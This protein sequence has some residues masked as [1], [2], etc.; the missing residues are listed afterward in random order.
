M[1]KKETWMFVD[2]ALKRLLDHK[3][4]TV[5]TVAEYEPDVLYAEPL[6]DLDWNV[7][8]QKNSPLYLLTLMS[9]DPQKPNY[10]YLTFE[11]NEDGV[12]DA[13]QKSGKEMR[14]IILDQMF[15]YINLST[16]LW[17]KL[18]QD[19]HAKRHDLLKLLVVASTSEFDRLLSSR[20]K[21]EYAYYFK[22]LVTAG[23]R[24][25]GAYIPVF[26]S[27]SWRKEF[28]DWKKEITRY[29]EHIHSGMETIYIGNLVL[30]VGEMLP[31]N[32]N[33]SQPFIE[34]GILRSHR[35]YERLFFTNL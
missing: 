31:S 24:Q 12:F 33:L 2:D 21:I 29:C 8:E 1:S 17:E 32:G 22:Q 14:T 28:S 35:N 20:R 26:K 18:S 10:N 25:E 6:E 27:D 3:R 7:I 23:D 5:T 30:T 34:I 9:I 4:K 15:E 16:Y 11:S 19:E 13:K